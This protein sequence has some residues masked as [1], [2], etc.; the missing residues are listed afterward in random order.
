MKLLSVA[1]CALVL[2]GCASSPL[3]N[4][5]RPEVDEK[6]SRM[7]TANEQA[8][9][10]RTTLEGK[11][12]EQVNG[13]VGVNNALL[14][15]GILTTGLA[16]GMVHHDAYTGTAFAGGATYLFGNQNL[17]KPRL[18]VYQSGI[19]AVNCSLRA[20]MPLNIGPAAEKSIADA[21]A[22][23]PAAAAKLQSVLAEVGAK[24]MPSDRSAEVKAKVV[25][26][27]AL[28]A[29]AA[30]TAADAADFVAR[31]DLAGGELSGTVEKIAED[32]DKLAS[33]TVPSAIS[34]QQS[35]AGLL[36]I[37]AGFA[38]G[39]KL[40]Q[41]PTQPTGNQSQ[42]LGKPDPVVD[43]VIV[44]LDAATSALEIVQKPLAAKLATYASRSISSLSECGVSDAVIA[45]RVDVDT[46]SFKGKTEQGLI[47][48]VSGGVK[49]YVARLRESPADGIEVKSP[50]PGD[51]NV[52]VKVPKALEKGT[53]T[54]LVMD[55]SN[56]RKSK[57]VLIV[58]G[59]D[60]VNAPV[61]PKKPVN[62]AVKV[63]TPTVPPATVADRLSGT[64]EDLKKLPP[65]GDKT[66]F[67]VGVPANVYVVTDVQAPTADST[68][69]ALKCTVGARTDGDVEKTV[70]A[71]L[72]RK[73]GELKVLRVTPA[74]D[75]QNRIKVTSDDP[76]CLKAAA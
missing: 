26:A 4:W 73:A 74:L 47:I 36:E 19:K 54:V 57:E 34:V 59:A 5:K 20:V 27:T 63:S 13:Q 62:D 66:R 61:E 72:I 43:A 44:E 2:S 23:L 40:N 30:K 35:L 49:P 28:L 60:P 21:A 11:A 24:A 69:V 16:L 38:P 8:V 18:A 29:T 7:A 48:A 25:A 71:Q 75:V 76:K 67:S 58:V 55:A 46:L 14:G 10:L 51:S 39:L 56:P 37:S 22:Q 17:S 68:V 1:I 42:G 33:D 50:L 70:R 15:L 41:L 31:A 9:S 64:T 12:A 6:K 3:L 45:L 52:E 32:V 65:L 53:Y